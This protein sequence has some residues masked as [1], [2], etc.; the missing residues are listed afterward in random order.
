MN[1]ATMSV[2]EPLMGAQSASDQSQVCELKDLPSD[3]LCKNLAWWAVTWRTSK[4]PQN[5][6]NCGWALA[7]VWGQ[8]IPVYLV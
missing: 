6:Q 4:K 1:K 7:Q 5:C 8:Y 2:C 3:S